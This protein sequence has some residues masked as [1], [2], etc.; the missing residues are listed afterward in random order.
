[1]HSYLQDVP[2]QFR[3]SVSDD[4]TSLV[5]SQMD[6]CA[7]PDWI[8]NLTALTRLDLGGNRLTELP[9]WVGNLTSLAQLNLSFNDLT[10]LPDW[11]GNLTA[12]EAVAD[13]VF[14]DA[15][16]PEIRLVDD[17]VALAN[18]TACSGGSGNPVVGATAL[19]VLTE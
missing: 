15:C 18:L 12:L 8:A 6:L 1:V 13:D 3:S 11:V 5:L 7:V 4:G 9:D 2:D 14:T 17:L 19:E 16:P 10:E